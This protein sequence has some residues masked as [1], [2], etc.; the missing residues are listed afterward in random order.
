MKHERYHLIEKFAG[1]SG[2]ELSPD[3]IRLLLSFEAL[4]SAQALPSGLVSTADE[5]RLLERHVLDCLRAARAVEDRD[6][7]AFDLGSGAGLPGIPVAI[8]CPRLRLHLVEARG[9]RSAVL[10]QMI[11][12]LGVGNTEV[13]HSRIELIPGTADLCFAR[14][15]APLE[16]SWELSERLL[17]PGG[18]LVYFAG[19]GLPAEEILLAERL[20]NVVAVRTLPPVL[21]SSGPLVIMTRR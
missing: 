14:A 1:S 16:R 4:L 9:H 5:G 18:R 15:L 6:R 20:P 12:E 13:A 11:R 2:L 10:E 8:A 3:Q 7:E 21:A 19:E 17:R